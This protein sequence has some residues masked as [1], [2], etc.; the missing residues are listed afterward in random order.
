M[1]IFNRIKGPGATMRRTTQLPRIGAVCTNVVQMHD[2][3]REAQT[4]PET[5]ASR[6]PAPQ[7]FSGRAYLL[8]VTLLLGIVLL[9]GDLNLKGLLLS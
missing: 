7:G 3:L 5:K 1:N 9:P 6:V 8:R 4:G 2:E